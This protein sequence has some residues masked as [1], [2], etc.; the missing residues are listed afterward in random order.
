MQRGFHIIFVAAAVDSVRRNFC[1]SYV[2]FKGK[3]ER[4]REAVESGYVCMCV[5]KEASLPPGKY[6]RYLGPFVRSRE[7]KSKINR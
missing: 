4:E 7:R 5:S 1:S 3:R 6:F 2:T